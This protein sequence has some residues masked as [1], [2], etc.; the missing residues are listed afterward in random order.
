MVSRVI[1]RA[2]AYPPREW[3]AMAAM[4]LVLGAIV[5]GDMLGV[6][7]AVLSLGPGEAF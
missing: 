6:S 2:S 1:A 4:G 7:L 3:L 5:A